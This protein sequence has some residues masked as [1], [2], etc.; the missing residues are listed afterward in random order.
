MSPPM[1]A[2][3]RQLANT[4]EPSVC[5]GNAILSNSFDHLFVNAVHCTKTVY[6]LLIFYHVIGFYI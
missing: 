1:W 4:I 6:M 2:H 3:W 5:G